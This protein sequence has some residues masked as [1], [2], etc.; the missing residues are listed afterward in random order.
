MVSRIINSLFLSSGDVFIPSSFYSASAIVYG[1]VGI[2]DI[3]IQ[4]AMGLQASA[5][6]NHEFDSGTQ[7][8]ARLIGGDATVN[9][10]G[11]NFPY[12]SCNLNFA[13]DAFMNP[14]QTP[15]YQAPL[16]RK[17]TSSVVFTVGGE[18][19]GVVGA[20]TPTLR[21]SGNLIL[22]T[23]DAADSGAYATDVQGVVDL[24]STGA[25]L[26]DPIVAYVT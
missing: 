18:K 7:N 17:V 20:T 12:L 21:T 2:G 22:S 26:V 10:T 23:Y 11:T 24:N 16:A 5:L 19:I 13:P 25:S 3:L 6:G 4:N 14:L 8:L 1:A 9:F 15:R